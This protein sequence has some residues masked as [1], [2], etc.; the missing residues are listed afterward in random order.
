[1]L[2][3][4]NTKNVYLAIIAVFVL[5]QIIGIYTGWQYLQLIDAGVAQPIFED[6]SDPFNALQLMFYIL[7]MTAFLLI[8]IRF[9]KKL[10]YFL[11]A[12]AIFFTSDIVFELAIPYGI[13]PLPIGMVLAFALTAWKMLRPTILSQNVA[14]IFSVSGAGA[15]IGASFDILPVVIFIL[16]LS[17]YDFISVFYTKHMVY[18]AKA[19]TDRPTAF[20]AAFPVKDKVKKGKVTKYYEHVFQ[21]GGGDLVIPLVFSVSVLNQY[22]FTSMI[23]SAVGSLVALILLFN[24]LMNKSVPLPALPPIAAGA[25]IGFAISLLI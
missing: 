24:Y 25:F 6:P 23:F 5:V 22:G 13:G 10:I 11:E 9:K 15:I 19:L 7:I 18:M 20:T 1:M 2:F 4:F 17:A 3:Q 14:L 21:L 8:L 12:L 16:L